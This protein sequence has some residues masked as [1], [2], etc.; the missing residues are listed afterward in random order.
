MTAVPRELDE[1]QDAGP[2]AWASLLAR[3]SH[4]SVVKHFDAYAD[5]GWDEPEMALDPTDPRFELTERDSLGATAWYKALPQETRARLGL[6]L[7]ASRM[8]IGLQFES[9]LKQGLLQYAAELPNN[10][11]EFRYAY[12]EVIEEAHHSL[13]F[14][15]FVNRSGFDAAGLRR[16]DR[17]GASFVIGL[18]RR[19][20]ALF[21]IFVLSGEDPIDHVQRRVLREGGDLHPLC[22]RIMR[23]HVTEEAR[24][25][26]FARHFV[27]KEVPKMSRLQKAQLAIGAPIIMS[28]AAQLMLKPSTQ[29]VRQYSIPRS[30]IDEAYTDNAQFRAETMESLAKVRRL[31]KEVGLITPVY[32]RLWKAL[33][34]GEK[35]AD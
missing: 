18:A 2:D 27:K 9:I 7:I 19:F 29:I 35:A 26:S 25:L 5:V 34:I 1:E 16:M 30:V 28:V 15:E 32:G 31:C 24:H 14:Q 6:D 10:S 23:I 20:P 8:K 3:L 11:P 13:M 21:F 22:E 17:I 12:H 4:Q 33:G